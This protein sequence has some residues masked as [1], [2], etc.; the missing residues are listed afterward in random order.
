MKNTIR[1]LQ[2]EFDRAELEGDTKK[3]R[4]LI[5]EDFISIGPR[6]FLM[7]K[8]AWIGR[9][10]HFKYLALESSEVDVRL[11][12]GAAI[13]RCIQRNRASFKGDEMA[14]AVRVSQVWV[15]QGEQWRLAAIQFSPLAE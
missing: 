9:H 11:Y 15:S 14:H 4:P 5:A 6:G 10:V 12:D 8:E 7:D 1:Q 2:E 3:L 13:L